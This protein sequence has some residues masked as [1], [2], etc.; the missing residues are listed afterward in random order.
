MR[1]R[2]RAMGESRAEGGLRREGSRGTQ[3]STHIFGEKGLLF[4]GVLGLLGLLHLQTLDEGG[5][6]RTKG[7]Q[8]RRQG[9]GL[10]LLTGTQQR[11]Q[12]DG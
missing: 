2:P 4:L 6:L 5:C 9:K 3:S 10:G 1:S 7:G 12:Q 8:R 11:Q